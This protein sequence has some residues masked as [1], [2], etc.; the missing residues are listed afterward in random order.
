[1]LPFCV[2]WLPKAIA[3]RGMQKMRGAVVGTQ[4]GRGAASI[5]EVDDIAHLHLTLLDMRQLM[6]V[7]AA[8]RLCG[9]P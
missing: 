8:Q 4:R 7:Q 1:M 6:R 3:E 9:V 5:F 2:T